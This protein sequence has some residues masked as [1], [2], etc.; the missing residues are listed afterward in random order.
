[1]VYHT[2][3]MTNDSLY[4][5]GPVALFNSK[6][7]EYV[8]KGFVNRGAIRYS[9]DNTQVLIEEDVSMFTAEDLALEGVESFTQEEMIQYL[10][11]NKDEWTIDEE[12]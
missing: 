2:I 1:M 9:L 6:Y 5:V 8:A 12:I 4:V 11:E 10:E 7:D 3:K